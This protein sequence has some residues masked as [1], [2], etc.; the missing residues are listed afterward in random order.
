M[1]EA[2]REKAHREF[3]LDRQVEAVEKFYK[4]MISLGK[5]KK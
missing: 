3:R 4:E 1:G 2:A 5:W